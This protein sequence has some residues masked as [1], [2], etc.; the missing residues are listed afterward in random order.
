[1]SETTSVT[2]LAEELGVERALL[3]RGRRALAVGG[4]E[5][6]RRK[7]RPRRR[8][9]APAGMA[10]E[11]VSPPL[12]SEAA[13]IAELEH[14][15]GEQRVLLVFFRATLRDVRE[16]RQRRDGPGGRVSTP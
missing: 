7:C 13:R 6:L 15:I 10:A 5:G 1:M 2:G 8:D 4:E 3:Y 11:A 14:K 16:R 12:I 9:V